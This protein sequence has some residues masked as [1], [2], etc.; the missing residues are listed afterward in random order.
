MQNLLS[1][2]YY[3]CIIIVRP[4]TSVTLSTSP[5]VIYEGLSYTITCS[6]ELFEELIG[7]TL[8]VTWTGPSGSTPSDIVSGSGTSYTSIVGRTVARTSDG[9]NYTCTVRVLSSLNLLSSSRTTSG[10]SVINVGKLNFVYMK[11]NM[12]DN[13]LK[14]QMLSIS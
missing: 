13:F 5:P 6:I 9:G 2:H 3:T 11:F 4:P 8:D 10:F 12:D 7:V 14:R 1:V